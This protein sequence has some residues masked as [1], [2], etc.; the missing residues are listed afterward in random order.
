MS[1]FGSTPFGLDPFGARAADHDISLAA[2]SPSALA[3]HGA[4]REWP[5]L[6]GSDS[7]ADLF[8]L[9]LAYGFEAELYVASLLSLLMDSRASVDGLA[10]RGGWWADAYTLLTMLPK[11]ARPRGSE[12]WTLARAKPSDETAVRAQSIITAAHA[13]MIDAGYASAVSCE[14]VCVGDALTARITI[15]HDGGR[16]ILTTSDL[17]RVA[18]ADR[19]A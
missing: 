1:G 16:L 3:D 9:V 10:A 19:N 14:A 5:I 13:W 11:N 18:N 17:W 4:T 15:D 7:S 6:I 12:L 2:F 8:E